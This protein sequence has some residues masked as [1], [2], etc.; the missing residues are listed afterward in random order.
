MVSNAPG[1]RGGRAG[2]LVTVPAGI[3]TVMGVVQYSNT[4]AAATSTATV[5][6][7]NP[8][9]VYGYQTAPP[10]V[11]ASNVAL[12][13]ASLNLLPDSFVY[14]RRIRCGARRGSGRRSTGS[15]LGARGSGLQVRGCGFGGAPPTR[16]ASSRRAS[17]PSERNRASLVV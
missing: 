9:L 8:P 4:F 2:T 16:R 3:V 14:L 1:T 10:T 17:S 6:V 11:V 13:G 7:T 12:T 5:T 15:G